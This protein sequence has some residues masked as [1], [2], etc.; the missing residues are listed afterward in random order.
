MTDTALGRAR[1]A[2]RPAVASTTVASIRLLVLKAALPRPPP[3]RRPSRCRRRRAPRRRRRRRARAQAG[4][5]PRGQATRSRRRPGRRRRSARAE[6]AHARLRDPLGHAGDEPE[7]EPAAVELCEQLQCAGPR[8]PV[9]RVAEELAITLLG[10]LAP[11]GVGTLPA[12]TSAIHAS[13][14]PYG[15]AAG[16]ARAKHVCERVEDRARSAEAACR[17][18][19]KAR[20]SQLDRTSRAKRSRK[21]RSCVTSSTVPG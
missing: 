11:A 9:R 17:R 7:A 2:K 18:R 4:S 20:A 8:L 10:S 16:T 12:R 14:V 13:S 21:R 1:R 5:A 19:R 6:A 3:P 15:R